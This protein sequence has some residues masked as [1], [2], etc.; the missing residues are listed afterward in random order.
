MTAPSA[1]TGA[2]D[3]RA[4]LQEVRATLVAHQA[5]AF[6]ENAGGE[7]PEGGV[8]LQNKTSSTLPLES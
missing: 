6:V 1:S 7:I 5:M 8:E 4:K 2:N 3:V